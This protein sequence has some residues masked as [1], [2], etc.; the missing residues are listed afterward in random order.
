MKKLV[1]A[2]ILNNYKKKIFNENFK[3]FTMFIDISGFISFKEDENLEEWIYVIITLTEKYG[4]YFNKVD[5]GNKDGFAISLINI[6][7]FIYFI[8]GIIINY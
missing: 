8:T 6:K 3:A 7:I 1:P 2:F 4:G 5:F